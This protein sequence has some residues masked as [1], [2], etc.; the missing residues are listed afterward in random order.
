M[1]FP[2]GYDLAGDGGIQPGEC[3]AEEGRPQ[4]SERVAQVGT[5]R[6]ALV[7]FPESGVLLLRLSGA[8]QKV[9]CSGLLALLRG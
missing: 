2:Y 4:L 8:F 1:R 6:L 9:F 5:T 7:N 3:S